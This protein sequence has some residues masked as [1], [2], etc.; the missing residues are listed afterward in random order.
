[1]AI[2]TS[3]AHCQKR[4]SAPNEYRDKKVEC[5]S[6]GRRTVVRAKEDIEKDVEDRKREEK[7]LAADRE[8]IALIE[9]IETRGAKRPGRP[10]FEAFQTGRSAVRNYDP[11]SPSRQPRLRALSD[12]VVLGAYLELLLVAVGVGMTIY[13]WIGGVIASAV[14]VLIALVGW[15]ILGGALY[16]FFKAL[17]ELLLAAADVADQ[18]HDTVQLLLDLRE[19]LDEEQQPPEA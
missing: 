17:G 8:K 18:S 16:V 12:F 4:F 15:L 10:Y 1:M 2:R 19:R 14:V 13:L 6:C 7:L 9:T 3:C 5:P 11:R